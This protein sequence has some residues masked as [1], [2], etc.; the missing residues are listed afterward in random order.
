MHK[1]SLWLQNNSAW[2]HAEYCIT[3]PEG[4]C[5]RLWAIVTECIPTIQAREDEAKAVKEKKRAQDPE[6]RVEIVPPYDE[7]VHAPAVA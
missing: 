2:C 3:C 6:R 1:R 4:C 5:P 7:D